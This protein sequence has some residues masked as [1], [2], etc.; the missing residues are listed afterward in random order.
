M[1][2]IQKSIRAAGLRCFSFKAS[3][4]VKTDRGTVNRESTTRCMSCS[5]NNEKIGLPWNIRV[6]D[7]D[8]GALGRGYGLVV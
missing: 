7:G 1:N 4:T 6:D 3:A 8:G 5:G 2:Q